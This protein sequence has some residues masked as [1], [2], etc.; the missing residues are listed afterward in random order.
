MTQDQEEITILADKW[1]FKEKLGI[2]EDAYKF[3]RVRKNLSTFLGAAG[4]GSSGA[5]VASSSVVATTFFAKSGILATLGL[6]AA[7]A[8]PIGWVVGAGALAGGAYLGAKMFLGKIGDKIDDRM[9]IKI[10][11]HINTPLD[12]IADEVLGLILPLSLR[13]AKADDDYIT[14]SEGEAISGYYAKEWGYTRAFVEEA[15][16]REEESLG[17]KPYAELAESL[18][19]YCNKNK[20]CNRDAIVEFLLK[21]L[22]KFIREEENPKHRERKTLALEHLEGQFQK[23]KKTPPPSPSQAPQP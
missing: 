3:L 17:N 6:G 22:K 2:G 21:H 1:R 20:D 18:V 15:I 14:A 23:L 16:K 19:G 10:P 9:M 4:A 8:T 11:R 5:L 7:A 12:V 13:V